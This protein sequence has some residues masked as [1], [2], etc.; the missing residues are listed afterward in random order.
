MGL[1]ARFAQRDGSRGSSRAT[2]PAASRIEMNKVVNVSAAVLTRPD[3]TVLLGQRA[4]GT[5]Y[6][7]YWEFPGGKVEAGETPRQALVRELR[8]EL[9]H[10]CPEAYPW[11]MR[12]HV[13]EHAHV[14]LHFSKSRAGR[15]R[16]TTMSTLPWRG[17]IPA[18]S[19]SRRCSCQW[20]DSQ[21][22]CACRER[23]ALPQAH[24]WGWMLSWRRSKPRSTPVAGS[25]RCA[26]ATSPAQLADFVARVRLREQSGTLVIV[27]ASPERARQTSA[28][29]V[30]LDT[31]TLLRSASRPAFE[32]V[33]A[34]CH[35][36]AELEKAASL[37]LDYA[38][39]GP[40]GETASHPGQP[41]IG[42]QAFETLAPGCRYRCWR[43]AA[44]HLA[45]CSTPADMAP[46]ALPR[47][48]VCGAR[49][50]PS[51]SVLEF[52][53]IGSE[54][55]TLYSSEAQA[56]RSILRQRSLQ[57]GRHRLSADHS[58]GFAAI[59]A[60]D[61][62]SWHGIVSGHCQR[63]QKVSSKFT[64]ASVCRS[65][66]T[67]S[68]KHETDVE[69]ILV[70]ADLGHRGDSAREPHPDHLHRPSGHH[71]LID[72][73]RRALRS[74]RPLARSRRSTMVRPSRMGTIGASQCS[75]SWRRKFRIAVEPE[76]IG[77]QVEFA[78]A[79]W[80]RGT[81]LD[82]HQPFVFPE[83]LADLSRH[84]KAR[85][86]DCSISYKAPESASSEISGLFRKVSRICRCRSSSLNQ[87]D[88]QIRP[89]RH[90]QHL[91]GR[92][93]RAMMG[94]AVVA[95]AE[96][97]DPTEQILQTEQRANAL[98]QRI[99]VGNHRVGPLGLPPL[100]APIIAHS[101]SA[102][103]SPACAAK[104]GLSEGFVPARGSCDERVD[105]GRERG[106]ITTIVDD[107]VSRATAGLPLRLRRHDAVDPLDGQAAATH[108]ALEL[109]LLRHV[110]HANPVAALGV[111]ADSTSSGTTSTT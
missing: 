81:A 39:L 40:V 67:V 68:G 5:F 32:W 52:A 6:P 102:A 92:Q 42:W 63:L 111:A 24:C 69:R 61:D 59:R 47:S 15:A 103:L 12:E 2:T 54:P 101:L 76:M 109:D 86:E 53:R 72:A 90:F 26:K 85:L 11:L 20:P 91:E 43:W 73:A 57:N 34:S 56:P 65:R 80:N 108:D 29:G 75:R 107:V 95:A 62:S 98:I 79:T 9:R 48:A 41:G 37:E 22:P 99:F 27:N 8:E 14:R 82:C 55:G 100:V 25:S 96:V 89:A 30:H 58:L 51:R 77:R 28:D 50:E 10:R 49:V 106:K 87:I 105:L 71:Q 78:C 66:D 35:N 93:K 94:M 1:D 16:S 60:L 38:L 84:G 3:G 110:H 17:S 44:C 4:A 19:T 33:G 36:R 18:P 70:G 74:G 46:T 104:P 45:R 21:V 31:A 13:Y 23:W 88:L 64:S 7:G 83:V 97:G